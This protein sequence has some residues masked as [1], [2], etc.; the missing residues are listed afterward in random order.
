[1]KRYKAID[2]IGWNTYSKWM[3]VECQLY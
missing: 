1:M 2:M 3:V